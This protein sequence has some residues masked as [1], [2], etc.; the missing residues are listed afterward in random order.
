MPLSWWRWR[1]LRWSN[2]GTQLSSYSRSIQSCSDFSTPAMHKRGRMSEIDRGKV[3]N[4]SVT[5]FACLH[6][7][8]MLL[9]ISSLCVTICEWGP[10]KALAICWFVWCCFNDSKFY[11]GHHPGWQVNIRGCERSRSKIEC[12][13]MNAKICTMVKE[14]YCF[15]FVLCSSFSIQ[16]NIC[17][18]SQC[19]SNTLIDYEPQI[20][21]I[22]KPDRSAT[23]EYKYTYEYINCCLYGFFDCFFFFSRIWRLFVLL[24]LTC[25]HDEEQHIH[26]D[27]IKL[28]HIDILLLLEWFVFIW[29]NRW[30]K[31]TSL[32]K[33]VRSGFQASLNDITY[34]DDFCKRESVTSHR[35]K[36]GLSIGQPM[37]E[38]TN[39]SL[40]P[41]LIHTILEWMG[42]IASIWV[43]IIHYAI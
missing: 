4:E 33:G 13:H 38:Q 32:L 29:L 26:S 21:E 34:G 41:I 23:L 35:D 24:G 40:L 6:V 16:F 25:L 3:H 43:T 27:H 7:I 36:M 1:Q 31:F 14:A 8:V 28:A 11:G 22:I 10:F 2:L 17:K 15:R 9:Y 18:L 5:M 39:H 42:Q 30:M 37:S 19:H 20:K 12:I